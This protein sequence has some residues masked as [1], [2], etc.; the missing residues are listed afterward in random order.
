M[1]TKTGDQKDDDRRARAKRAAK[2]RKDERE[3]GRGRLRDLGPTRAGP[4]RSRSNAEARLGAHVAG[5][6]PRSSE[7]DCYEMCYCRVRMA[8]L[9]TVLF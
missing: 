3:S 6:V 1:R 4:L 9:F 2:G 8:R 5:R 7:P